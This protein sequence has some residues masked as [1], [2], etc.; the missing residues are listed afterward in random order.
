MDALSCALDGRAGM[1]EGL[2]EPPEWWSL[3]GCHG[4][5]AAQWTIDRG[6]NEALTRCKTV[7][8]AC[9]ASAECLRDAMS[10]HV[11]LRRHGP[12]RCGISG[13][14][15]WRRVEAIVTEF[16]PTTPADWEALAAWALDGDLADLLAS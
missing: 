13:Y 6:S 4:E 16:A 15:S 14:R 10:M 5:G 12:V 2:P 3:A 9:P 8:R 11:E 7:C 1:Y